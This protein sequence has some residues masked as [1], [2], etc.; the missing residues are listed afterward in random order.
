MARGSESRPPTAP[1][2]R[3]EPSDKSPSAGSGSTPGSGSNGR[4]R[5]TGPGTRRLADPEER[6]FVRRAMALGAFVW[7]AFFLVDLYLSLVVYP[8]APIALYAV[9]RVCGELAIFACY[10]ESQRKDVSSRRL[11]ATNALVCTFCSVL[12]SIMALRL[13]GLT[14]PYIHGLSL[15]IF[16]EALAV[17]APWRDTVWYAAPSVAS[18][19]VIVLIASF[20]DP[21]LASALR[22]SHQIAE[23]GA[24]YALLLASATIA[25]AS[26]Q[27]GWNARMQ[28]RKARQL[29]RY[30][31]EAR[32]GEGGMNEVW[33]AWDESLKRNVA[34]KLLRSSAEH[35]DRAIARFEREALALSR[36]TSPHT[37]RVFDF[38]A[39]D[40][41]IS[42]IAMEY[43]PGAD[44]QQLVRESGPMPPERAIALAIQ[45]CRSLAEAHAAGIVHRDIKPANLFATRL[46]DQHDVLKVL[47][48]GIARLV[49]D[50]TRTQSVRGTPAYMAPECWID[51][52]ADA[53]SDIYA[54]GATLYWLLCGQ[55]P[56]ESVDATRLLRAHML[57]APEAPSVMRGEPL[58][59]SLDDLVLRC[60]AKSP[61]ERI[62]S[63]EALET[64]LAACANELARAWTN[65]DARA[66]WLGRDREK[67]EER[68]SLVASSGPIGRA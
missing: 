29:G 22:D 12:I 34:L 18:F 47:D 2:V 20:F 37:V 45:V 13:G 16:V 41:G 23:L 39:S 58:P 55:P 56:F 14:S 30:R 66:F 46:G 32:I 42:Y 44:L 43:L 26:G 11:K 62:A 63:A 17:P 67:D 7:P 10:R 57:E 38:G 15:V 25:A 60:L 28:L 52:E 35:D 36:L 31:L 65:E 51:G 19:P 33:L 68:M 9:F 24:H 5:G 59:A 4:R 27:A 1:T 61:D 8:G 50:A 49:S 3:A 53:R 64:A 48:F 6:R 21:E 54:L 40:D